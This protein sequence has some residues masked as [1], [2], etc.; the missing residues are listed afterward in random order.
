[1]RLFEVCVLVWRGNLWVVG[2]GGGC[3]CGR[4]SGVLTALVSLGPTAV[5]LRDWKV[6]VVG[7]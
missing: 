4:S 1:M 6:E 5:A 7:L 2:L 3:C